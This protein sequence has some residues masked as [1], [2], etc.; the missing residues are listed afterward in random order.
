MRLIKTLL[1]VVA[2]VTLC[3]CGANKKNS[4]KNT[5]QMSSEQAKELMSQYA[6]VVL[7]AD[8]RELDKNEQMVV[9]YLM[10]AANVMNDIFWKQNLQEDKDV[11]LSKITDP[12]LRQY[13]VINYGPWD[14]FDG[15]QAFIAPYGQMPLGANCY[16]TDMTKEEFDAWEEP[17]KLS[18]YT[19]ITRDKK[20]K[21]QAVPYHEYF[22]PEV[23]LAVQ[24]IRRAAS[25]CENPQF[26]KYLGMR[27]EALLTDSY[28][29]SDML[30]MDVRDSK[31]DFVIG[32]I[33]NY[34]DQIYGVKDAYESYVLLK[35]MKASKMYANYNHYLPQLQK[36]LP[37]ED[38]YKQEVPGSE[39]DLAVYDVLYYAGDCN[40]AGKTIAINLPNDEQ[41]QLKKGT[42]KLQLRNAMRAKYD[43]I[44]VP[45]AGQLMTEE[46]MK[47]I[48]FDAFFANVMFHEVAHGMGI[49]TTLDGKTSVH[50]A[51]KEQYSALEEAK[52]DV[53]GLYLITELSRM[54]VYS[55]T[56]LIQNYTTFMAG[57]F[58]SVRFGASSA[59]GKANMLT[60]NYFEKNDA[61]S[62]N[63]QGLYH[64]NFDQMMKAVERLAGEIIVAQGNGDYEFVK[65]WIENDGVMTTQLEKDLA[66]INGVPV[67]I[68]FEMGPKECGIVPVENTIKN[69]KQ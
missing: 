42:R 10:S 51:L 65:K 26:K 24:Y 37:V 19:M 57:I 41:I 21:L 50:S 39:S 25:Y 14:Q 30:W 62:R 33:E 56:E 32:P 15:Q 53:L 34:I 31:I 43:Q 23:E 45:I 49:K 44:L 8:L 27:A 11:F 28:F 9:S 66:R 60:F 52:A 18:P 29:D 20:G 64:I 59:H 48:S 61:F 13:A 2:A 4:A 12:N 3:G 55:Q 6:K 63:Q 54:G 7:S 5:E 35:D 36:E 69:N 1:L 46:S 38:V 40:M 17:T 22:K 58:R 47:N 68:Y 16:P 67:D